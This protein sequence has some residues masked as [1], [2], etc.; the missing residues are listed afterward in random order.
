MISIKTNIVG[1]P[2]DFLI[3]ILLVFLIWTHWQQINPKMVGDESNNMPCEAL[4]LPLISLFLSL[5]CN[6][7]YLKPYILMVITELR[8]VDQGKPLHIIVC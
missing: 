5:T 7:L 2:K 4:G 1:L 3:R 6:P 8:N